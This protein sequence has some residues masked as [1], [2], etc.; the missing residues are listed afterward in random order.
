MI[1]S[2][3]TSLSGRRAARN[4]VPVQPES[5]ECRDVESAM[6]SHPRR[7]APA[8]RAGLPIAQADAAGERVVPISRVVDERL[9]TAPMPP[10][11]FRDDRGCIGT[12]VLVTRDDRS[13]SD[14][15]D[16]RCPQ[17]CETCATR[18]RFRGAGDAPRGVG[19][20][21]HGRPVEGALRTTDLASAGRGDSPAGQD[22]L[23][24][25]RQPLDPGGLA[26]TADEA[27]GR[28]PPTRA[29]W[30]AR[31][32]PNPAAGPY[33]QRAPAGAPARGTWR[34]R[35]RR[36]RHVPSRGVAG[37]APGAGHAGGRHTKI[38]L[39]PHVPLSASDL[40]VNARGEPGVG[41]ALDR[42]IPS[43]DRI[44]L[45]CAFV[46]WNGLRLLLPRLRTHC[47]QGRP[48][49]V[50]TTTYTARPNAARSTSS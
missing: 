4:G 37:R 16:L 18:A 44:D 32:E 33:L 12:G 24:A 8:L 14:E 27:R 15:R 20:A 50:I 29:A 35:R 13:T 48:L 41:H 28:R 11:R 9:L 2:M 39:R 1:Y 45:L 49:R 7:R 3:A 40:L 43:A 42:E 21:P 46:R 26:R 5:A 10:R 30:A 17:R 6:R 22:G 34:P 31:E 38:L 25:A 23:T 19:A 36:G 47:A